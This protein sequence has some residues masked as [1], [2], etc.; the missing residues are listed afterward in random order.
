M[1]VDKGIIKI[2]HLFGKQIKMSEINQIEKYAGKYIIKTDKK[3]LYIDT[4]IIEEKSLLAL[5]EVFK[6]LNVEWI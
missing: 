1:T 3:K 6:N 5:N 2:N 4:H